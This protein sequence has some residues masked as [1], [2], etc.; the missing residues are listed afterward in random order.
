MK[1]KIIPLAKKK[2]KILSTNPKIPAINA[3]ITKF[4]VKNI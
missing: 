3:T 1:S 2:I 4:P